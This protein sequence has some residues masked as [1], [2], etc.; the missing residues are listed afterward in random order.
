FSLSIVQFSTIQGQAIE[1]KKSTRKSICW[2]I[3]TK[4]DSK[5]Q[6]LDD[7]HLSG[8]KSLGHHHLFVETTLEIDIRF[9]SYPTK[10]LSHFGPCPWAIVNCCVCTVNKSI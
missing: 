5:H 10:H 2:T 6:S 3:E 7:H 9:L 8:K 4:T 1:I